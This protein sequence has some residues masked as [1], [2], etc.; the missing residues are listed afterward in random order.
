MP[1]DRKRLFIID[2]YGQIYRSYFA[3]MNNP[4]R[5]KEGNN[6]SAVYG[7]F[8]TIMSLIRQYQPQYLVVAMDAKGK[9]FR[10]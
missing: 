2:G 6:V 9:T 8:N 3:F 4:L 7:F 5:D 10:H 1:E